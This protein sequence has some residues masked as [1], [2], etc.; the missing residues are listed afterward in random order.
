M[1]LTRVH[2]VLVKEVDDWRAKSSRRLDQLRR[3]DSGLQGSRAR[4]RTLNNELGVLC[5]EAELREDGSDERLVKESQNS[6]LPGE[7]SR[8]GGGGG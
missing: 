3:A 2:R 5:R 1:N 4:P 6:S 7:G 8:P